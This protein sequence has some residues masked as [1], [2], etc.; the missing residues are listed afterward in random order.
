VMERYFW[1]GVYPGI[2]D[3]MRSYVVEVIHDFHRAL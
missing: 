3:E 2:T 1:V